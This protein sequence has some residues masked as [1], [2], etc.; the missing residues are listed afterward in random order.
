MREVDI[1]IP[2]YEGYKQT[3]DCIK[4]V[5]SSN[6]ESQTHI[7][8]INDFSPNKK[9]T[10]WLREKK[11]DNPKLFLHENE[12]NLGFIKTVNLGMSFNKARDVIL[13]NSDTIVPLNWVSKL[14]SQ[15]YKDSNIGTVTPFSNNASIFSFPNFNE[16]N[17]YDVDSLELIN[18]AFSKANDGLSEDV[19]TGHGFCL[20]IKRDCLNQVGLF[21]AVKFGRG[22]GE[23][24]D[25]CLRA[26]NANWRNIAALDLYVIHSGSASFNS[27]KDKGKEERLSASAKLLDKIYPG[28]HSIIQEFIEKDP[29][30]KYRLKSIFSLIKETPNKKVLLISH[31][32]GGGVKKYLQ[33]LIQL[34]ESKIQF[35][36]LKGLEG[37]KAKLSF[38]GYGKQKM[39]ISCNSYDDLLSV[40]EFIDIGMV[41]FNHTM[42]LPERFF[43][44]H[45]DLQC[46]SMFMIHDYYLIGSNP[47][48]TSVD[49]YFC[50]DK[51]TR[52]DICGRKNPL[53]DGVSIE[54]WRKNQLSFLESINQ[55]LVPSQYAKNIFIDYFPSLK[56]EVVYHSDALSFLKKPKINFDSIKNNGTV[57]VIG[58]L[59]KEKGADLLQNVALINSK[60]FLL[61]GYA[62]KKL[63]GVFEYGQYNQS[64]IERLI[65][66]INPDIIWFPALWPETYSYTLSSAILADVPIFAP[67]LGAFPERLKDVKNSR[68][69]CWNNDY[70]LVSD[71]LDEF[72]EELKNC[73][74]SNTKSN[75]KIY[76]SSLKFYE[77][78]AELPDIKKCNKAF[79]LSNFMKLLTY[80][81]KIVEKPQS[82]FKKGLL[83]LLIRIKRN[84]FIYALYKRV[85][86]SLIKYYKNYL[87]N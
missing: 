57:L 80:S 47:T 66:K 53:P 5:L 30:L 83:W 72:S 17:D 27:L 23:E 55:I 52:D 75:Y 85:P 77:S 48:L 70:Q 50:E 29:F 2:V 67:N 32:L 79:P 56:I 6:I 33:D 54:L 24:N 65:K 8:I 71:A 37:N 14:K 58:A 64:E 61:L 31:N 28:Y 41:Y 45:K 84:H 43:G 87:L 40:L 10:N 78:F 39:T 38:P 1:I 12:E 18:Q 35:I 86:K 76:D 7:H 19:P 68:I 21:D 26:I 63:Y 25:F 46:H 4:S 62:Y 20:F 36:C 44:I 9:I 51:T 15:A 82:K 3:V 13:L 69:Y 59:S 22:Y 34:E 74:R 11:Y 60:K 49:G 81:I 42:G 16:D 73:S